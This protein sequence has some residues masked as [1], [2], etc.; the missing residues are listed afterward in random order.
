MLQMMMMMMGENQWVTK[1]SESNTVCTEEFFLE[2]QYICTAL[3]SYQPGE[4][5][6]EGEENRQSTQHWSG[7][8]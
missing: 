7:P 5:V 8:T 4:N 3:S 1:P 6:G 2:T